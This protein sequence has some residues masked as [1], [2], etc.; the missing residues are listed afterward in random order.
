MRLFNR[1]KRRYASYGERRFSPW[2]IVAICAIGVLI[3]TVI[4]G[5]LLGLWLDEDTLRALREGESTAEEQEFAPTDTR[6][7]VHANA[8]TFGD[9]TDDLW[10]N[11]EVSIL[12]NTPDGTV[13]Y[14]S[15][16]AKHLGYPTLG[17]L[18]L[19]DGFEKLSA[20]ASYV[21]GVFHPRAYLQ[22]SADLRYAETAREAALLREFSEAGGNEIVLVGL[23]WDSEEID[24]SVLLDYIRDLR[25]I[26]SDTPIGVSIPLSV[27]RDGKNW[28]LVSRI[29]EASDFCL[30]DLRETDGSRSP[31]EWISEYR[32][33]EEQYRMRLLLGAW[34]TALFEAA[35]GLADVQTVTQTPQTEAEPTAKN[36]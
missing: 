29:D 30:L 12:I 13:L 33:F 23:P 28:K 15:P 9:A 36:E 6:K 31:E 34:Q 25:S 2:I 22:E 8:F 16:V 24:R 4:I 1:R 11:S 17:K 27:A 7:P 26:L 10:E 5:N 21:S 18:S 32:Y 14:P 20:A 19:S 3:L 35:S